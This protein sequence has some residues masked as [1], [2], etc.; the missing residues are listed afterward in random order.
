MAL[1]VF[2]SLPEALRAGYQVYD[3]TNAGYLVRTRTP[4]GWGL[5]I[6]DCSVSPRL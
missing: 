2:R 3:R 4:Q 5:A 6:V 1:V